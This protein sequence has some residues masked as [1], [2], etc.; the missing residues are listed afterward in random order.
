MN[1]RSI[2]LL[3][4][5]IALVTGFAGCEFKASSAN[6]SDAK[7]SRSIDEQMQ[8]VDPTT[9]FTTADKEVHATVMLANAP[10]ETKVRAIWKGADGQP[11]VDPTDVEA[12]GDKSNVHFTLTNANGL[13]PGQY[14]CDIYLDPMPSDSAAAPEKTLSFTVQ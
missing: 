2:V 7:L 1:R 12:G 8:A 5:M 6:I 10:A 11:L 14:T 3:P 9:T 4:V 13:R